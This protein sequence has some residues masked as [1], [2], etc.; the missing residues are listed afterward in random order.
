VAYEL[1]LA[2]ANLETQANAIGL[3]SHQMGG[4]DAA[5]VMD[6]FAIPHGWTPLVVVAVGWPGDVQ[7]LPERLAERERAPRTRLPVGS[8]VFADSW[9]Q[10]GMIEDEAVVA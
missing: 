4:F 7:R 3:V 5:A 6:A 8:L 2:V 1:G 9:E 10:P